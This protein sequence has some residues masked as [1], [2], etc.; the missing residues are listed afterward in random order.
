MWP[1][2]PQLIGLRETHLLTFIQCFLSFP[3][4]DWKSPW[5]QTF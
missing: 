3:A 4:P 2:V 1:E 5:K